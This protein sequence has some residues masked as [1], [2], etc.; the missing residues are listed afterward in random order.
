[1][2]AVGG[3][4]HA[5]RGDFIAH[6]SRAEMRFACSDARHFIGDDAEA[7]AFELCDWCEALRITHAHPFV[8]RADE[9]NAA[10]CVATT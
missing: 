2:H 1:M 10:E 9:L 6:C 7:R 8:A 4:H 5:T 3:N